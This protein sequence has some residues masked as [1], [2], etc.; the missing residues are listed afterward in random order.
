MPVS[1]GK[2]PKAKATRLH[3]LVVRSRGKCEACGEADYA[4]LQC[5][6][7]IPRR[8]N[9]TR[10]DEGNALCLCWTCHRR[11]TDW[12]LEWAN[13]VEEKVGL[14]YYN[15]LK[16]KA[17]AGVKVNDAFWLAEVE[18]LSALMAQT[19]GDAA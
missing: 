19:G 15:H 13:F 4:R 9:A 8:Y 18:R 3:S 12:P 10:T 16:R 5:A 1:Y 17:Q 6:H 11:F 7:I 14:S 2:G